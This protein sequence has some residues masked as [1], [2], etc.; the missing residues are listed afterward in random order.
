MIQFSKYVLYVSNLTAHKKQT[1]ILQTQTAICN[2]KLKLLDYLKI[3]VFRIVTP[4]SLV[5]EES[6]F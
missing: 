1:V 2:N 3:T 6:E 4:C 5:R